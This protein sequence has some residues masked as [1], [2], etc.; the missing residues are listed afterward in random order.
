MNQAFDFQRWR[1][2]VAKQW[3]DNRNKYVL[4]LGAIAALMLLWFGFLILVDRTGA[5]GR[6][7]QFIAYYVGLFLTGALFASLVFGD[8]ANRPKAINFMSVPASQLEKVLCMAF[9]C[10]VVFFVCYTVAFYFADFIMVK[11]SN[12]VQKARLEE[13]PDWYHRPEATVT[14]VFGKVS[15]VNNDNPFNALVV[16]LLLF[17]AVQGAYALGSIYF[18]AYSFIKTTITLLLVILFFVFLVA[19]VLIPILPEGRFV[20]FPTKFFLNTGRYATQHAVV[21][22]HWTQNVFFGFFK[23]ILTPAFWV[24]TYFRLKEKE[25]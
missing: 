3:N 8:L 22:P 12:A 7:S 24:I 15:P 20:D 4:S 1:L 21:L 9:Y 23:Y 13:H 5:M 25:V 2:L 6:D 18:P 14:N 17:F 10:V 19:K 11:V 16:V